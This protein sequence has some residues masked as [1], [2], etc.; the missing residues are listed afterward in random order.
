M[1]TDRRH[2]RCQST[3]AYH[4]SCGQKNAVRGNCVFDEECVMRSTLACSCVP[5]SKYFCSRFLLGLLFYCSYSSG[6]G[7][8]LL[9]GEWGEEGGRQCAGLK[10]LRVVQRSRPSMGKMR[11]LQRRTMIVVMNG[12]DRIENTCGLQ[13]LFSCRL[14]PTF[15]LEYMKSE[16]CK[17]NQVGVAFFVQHFCRFMARVLIHYCAKQIVLGN[18]DLFQ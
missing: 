1:L 14:Y 7:L 15:L 17:T 10:G 12:D 18:C 6:S 2:D 5:Y 9:A 13:I 11:R 4:Y 3:T 8:A 16:T